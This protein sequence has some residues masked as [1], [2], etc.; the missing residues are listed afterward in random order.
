M[1]ST[2][3]L[4]SEDN[5]TA[6]LKTAIDNDDLAIVLQTGEGGEFPASGQFIV[7]MFLT[8]PDD[9]NEK[10]LIDSVSTDTLTVNASGRGYD[11]TDATS[12][13]VNSNVQLLW[14]SVQVENIY[15]AIN[16][17]EDGT[18]ELATL[19]T[20]G[21]ATI[22]D[23]AGQADLN[24]DG[25][26]E[27]TRNL[28]FRT[29]GSLR[30]A[31]A[32]SNGAEAGSD[33][34]SDFLVARYSDAGTFFDTPI[35]I[36]R[37]DGEIRFSNGY[38]SSGVDI[39]ASGNLSMDGDLVVDGTTTMSGALNH[40]GTTAGFYGTAPITVPAVTGATDADKI[41]SILAQLVALGLV[42]DSTT[43]G[44]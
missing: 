31:V 15:T 22:G 21:N 9:G 3:F 18:T 29:G 36:Q 41:T 11:S 42:T 19:S 35:R 25:V 33:S 7:T 30:W 37:D 40:D 23:G 38:G 13:A 34:G 16:N 20:A 24:I 4:G 10:I 6:T 14:E 44:T 1:A 5:A 2:T 43:E 26:D 28:K 32:A 8:D 39:D 17:I 27:T 12:W